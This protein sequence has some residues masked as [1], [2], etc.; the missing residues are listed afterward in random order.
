M[1]HVL[2]VGRI[3]QDLEA[4]PDPDSTERLLRLAV[5]RRQSRSGVPAPGVSYLEIVV[6]WPRDLDYSEL[7]RGSLVAVSGL[8]ERNEFRD[9]EGRRR[10]AQRI[11]ADWIERL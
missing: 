1:N 8:I 9:A 10:W 6:P 4:R 7:R 5:P 3:E 2:L 11:I